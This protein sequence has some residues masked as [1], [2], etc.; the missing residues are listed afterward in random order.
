MT[1]RTWA[2]FLGWL[3]AGG[4]AFAFA[5]ATPLESTV[6]GRVPAMTAKR[7]DQKHVNLPREL[8]G[9]RTLAVV[10][11]GGSQKAEARSW[12]DGLRLRDEP[13]ISWLKLPVLHDPGTEVARHAIVQAMMARHPGEQDRARMVPIFTSQQ[14]FVRAAGLSGADHASILVLDRDGNVLARAEGF[15][16]EGKAQAL[17]ETLLAQND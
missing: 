6:L 1:T 16:D 14:A 3:A 17:R 9:K 7:L 5:L 12:I 2:P 15:Y 13:A 10:V 11:F 4:T 8:P